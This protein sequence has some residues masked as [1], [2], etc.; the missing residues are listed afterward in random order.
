[1][2]HG[3]GIPIEAM[4]R[5][6]SH[7]GDEVIR[8]R[9]ARALSLMARDT[10]A[11][12]LVHDTRLMET[13]SN[14]ALRDTSN[15]VRIEAAVAFACWPALLKAPMAQHEAILDALTHLANSQSVLPEVMARALKDQAS[16]PENRIPKAHRNKFLEALAR[17]ATS[18]EAP[19]LN[20]MLAMDYRVSVLTG[21]VWIARLQIGPV[22]I[23]PP[24]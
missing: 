12:L 13:L 17:I 18:A 19:I 4:K 5:L 23:M 7:D 6:V 1:V 3:V 9:A 15:D 24:T 10:S 21:L 8:Q 2:F 20:F 16:H 11:P 14:R 22:Q